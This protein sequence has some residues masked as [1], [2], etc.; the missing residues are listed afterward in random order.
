MPAGARQED[1]LP[2]PTHE[3]PTSTS[4]QC[5]I[6]TR[7]SVSSN[8]DLSSCEVQYEACLAYVISQRIFG[9]RLVDERFDDEGYSGA[10]LDRPGLRRLAERVRSGEVEVV[11][12]QRFDRL[13]RSVRGC[14]TLLDL[15][16]KHHVR[17]AIVTAPEL[18]LSSEDNFMLSILAS[19]AE[20]EREMIAGR[21]ADARARLKSERKRLAGAVPFGYNADPRTKQLEPE[22]A[23][24]EVVR[25]MFAEAA[26]GRRPTQIAAEANARQHRTKTNGPWSARQIVA[27]LRNPVYAG[28]FRDGNGVRI[29]CHGS[30]IDMDQFH[31]AGRALD[32]RRTARP[33]P[34][35]YGNAWPLKGKILCSRCDRLL[36][37]HSCRRGNKVYRYYRCRAT[38]RG[39]PPC[40]YQ[41]AAGYIEF[42]IA[43]R[44][45][46]AEEGEQLLSGRLRQIVERVVYDPD[47][48]RVYLKWSKDEA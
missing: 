25:W 20:F 15:F 23:E 44:Y 4:I 38:A 7:Q 46:K 8:D 32:S 16:K 34:G 40:G 17:L 48:D 26:A 9:W 31:A 11:V 47:E 13:S 12:V 22:P 14:A 24:A 18:G 3:V 45:P 27:T 35:D 39:R 33:K 5:A 30:I 29:G 41:I 42:M 1:G 36:S 37:P 19:F 2:Q 43:K 10:T 6:Y 28:Y 21:I